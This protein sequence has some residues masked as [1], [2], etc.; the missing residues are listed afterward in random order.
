M[1]NHLKR[2][3]GERGLGSCCGC[4]GT[5]IFNDTA[6]HFLFEGVVSTMVKVAADRCLPTA[7]SFSRLTVRPD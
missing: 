6:N 4:G 3:L 1:E 5:R 2:N 7:V